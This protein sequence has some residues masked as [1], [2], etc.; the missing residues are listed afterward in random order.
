MGTK[1][2][3]KKKVKKTG[4]KGPTK[5]AAKAPVNVAAVRERVLQVI[6][7]KAEA[8][9]S[10]NVEEA[11]NGHVTQ[12]KYLFEVLG[13]FPATASAEPEGEEQRPGASLVEPV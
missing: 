7:E 11:A 10:A 2:V 12:L 13:I 9:T 6:A 8:M 5:T 3:T 4:S 1:A